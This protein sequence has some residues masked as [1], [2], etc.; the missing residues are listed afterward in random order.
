ML[1]FNIKLFC[2]FPPKLIVAHLSPS[3]DRD[4]CPWVST[5]AGQNATNVQPSLKKT[6]LLRQW[7]QDVNIIFCSFYRD[8][9]YRFAEYFFC[10]V[11]FVKNWQP[12]K[13]RSNIVIFT[14]HRCCHTGYCDAWH[15]LPTLSDDFVCPL[16]SSHKNR[17]NLLFEWHKLYAHWV[18]QIQPQRWTANTCPPRR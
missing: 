14:I 3:V 6:W 7:Q 18:E 4:I 2:S 17:W 9:V 8:E 10:S 1:K 15:G 11:F 5:V 13:Y 16:Y 12:I